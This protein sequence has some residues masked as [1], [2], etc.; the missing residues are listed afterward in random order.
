MFD[1]VDLQDDLKHGID[2][3]LREEMGKVRDALPE[4]LRRC[5][6]SAKFKDVWQ[7]ALKEHMLRETNVKDICCQ[8]ARAGVIDNTWSK[9]GRRK[10][11][12]DDLILLRG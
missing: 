7:A 5:G 6:G 1:D 9:A 10:P 8:L 3:V 12:D 4:A 2:E 11:G